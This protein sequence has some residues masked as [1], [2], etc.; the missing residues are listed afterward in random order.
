MSS[1]MQGHSSLL[2]EELGSC[3]GDAS[4]QLSM[5]G[6]STAPVPGDYWELLS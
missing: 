4:C 5:G 2:Q 3:T 6:H 1:A